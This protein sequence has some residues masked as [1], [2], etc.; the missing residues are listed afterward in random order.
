MKTNYFNFKKFKDKYL[1]TNEEGYF[2]FVNEIQ[3]QA[4]IYGNF[5]QLAPKAVNILKDRYFLYEDEDEVFA[6]R[7]IKDYRGNKSYLFSATSLH[8][9]VLTNSCNMACVYCQA[10]DSAQKKRGRMELVT[11]KKAIDVIMQSPAK[12][13]C[14]EF[15]GG[16]PLINFSV[17]KQSVE[18][19]EEKYTDRNINFSV[20]TN[21]LLLTEEM[22][23]FF[24]S[25]KIS[26]STSLDGD[27]IVHNMNRKKMEG[28]DTYDDVVHNI[29]KL[30]KAGVGI[31]AIQTTTKYS[32]SR[33]NEIVRA[34]LQVGLDFLFIRPLTSLGYAK[35]H[36]NDIGYTAEEFVEFYKSA[37]QTI[38]EY[39]C[40]GKKIVEGHAVIFLRK[41]LGHLSDNYMELRSPCGA[42][43]GQLAY[44][45]DGNVYTCDE[46]RMIAEMGNKSFLL[47]NV[48]RNTYDELMDSDV[49]QIICQSSVLESLPMCCDCVYHVYCGACPVINLAMADNVYQ[50]EANGYKCKI[51]KGMLDS[52]FELMYENKEIVEVFKS[53]I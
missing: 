37:L 51:Y 14:I 23:D 33:V 9:I 49:C 31:G 25:H 46:G 45:Y 16:E 3:L 4:L 17:I 8:I 43:V 6:Q 38:V 26:V 2:A 32:L 24:S 18:Y 1:I 42:G 22:I 5:M 27:R 41:I 28:S 35:A 12:D 40:S 50:H 39:N 30:K 34:Y 29:E 52:I 36:W 20:V 21:T 53:W 48:Y 15:Q 47:G 11:A 19:A 44:Y 7:A 10:Q 13:I